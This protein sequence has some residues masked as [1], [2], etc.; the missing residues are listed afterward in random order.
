MLKGLIAMAAAVLLSSAAY[1]ETP[2]TYT[3]KSTPVT[4]AE[5][6]I[7]YDRD[8]VEEKLYVRMTS[9]ELKE[10]QEPGPF[11]GVH[12]EGEFRLELVAK[13]GTLLH[14]LDLNPTFGG[15][16]LLFDRN[17]AF[18]IGFEDYNDDGYPDFS[19][20]QYASSNGYTYNLYS[21]KPEGIAVIHRDL[22]TADSRYSILYEKKGDASFKNFYYDMEKGE[23]AKTL[24]TWQSDRFIRTEYKECAPT[25]DPEAQSTSA[26]HWSFASADIEKL[27]GRFAEEKDDELLRELS[28]L[29]VFRFYAKASEAGDYSTQYALYIKD[30]GYEV[31][32]YKSF[33]ND[34]SQDQG[35]ADRSRQKWAELKSSYALTEEIDGNRAL[36]RMSNGT[37]NVEDE[38]GFQLIKNKDGI[39]KAAWMPMQ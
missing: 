20:G 13:D 12:W 21:L 35:E 11:A 14:T 26:S 25:S 9:G 17:R 37:G 39:W 32:S 10:E 29:D 36:I 5:S 31:P 4:I 8:G 16:S 18:N 7:D 34:I 3:A 15:E 23:M 2:E 38:K 1:V 19:I 22:Y 24:F 27:Y 30:S 33:L 6:D 28:P